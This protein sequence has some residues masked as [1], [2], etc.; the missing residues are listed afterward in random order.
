M[1]K[2]CVEKIKNTTK[3][4]SGIES[5]KSRI[6]YSIRARVIKSLRVFLGA[7]IDEAF[8]GIWSKIFGILLPFFDLGADE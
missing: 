5:I 3:C 1:K 8:G 6:V 4:I 2:S 7:A